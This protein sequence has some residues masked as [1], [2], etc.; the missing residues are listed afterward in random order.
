MLLGWIATLVMLLA[1]FLIP[2]GLPGLW[3]MVAV[4][5]VGALLGHVGPAA[6]VIVVAAAALAELLEFLILKSMSA[7]YGAPSGDGAATAEPV[8]TEGRKKGRAKEQ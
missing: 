3:V 7:R 2:L 4:V 1:I 6:L 5:G 8:A